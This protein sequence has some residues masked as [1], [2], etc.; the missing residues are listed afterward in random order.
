MPAGKNTFLLIIGT[1]DELILATATLNGQIV[2]AH[3]STKTWY[4]CSTDAV[5]LLTGFLSFKNGRRRSDY[6]AV[7][8][9][10]ARR[11]RTRMPEDDCVI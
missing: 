1:S 9:S 11:H 5:L 6:A 4:L 10:N 7:L 8:V 3:S 2:S